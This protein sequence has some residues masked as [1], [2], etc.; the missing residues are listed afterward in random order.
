MTAT[1]EEVQKDRY[2]VRTISRI[3]G[4]P[5]TTLKDR[6]IGKVQHGINPG[7]HPREEAIRSL[8]HS[9]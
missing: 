5:K 4:V 3:Y 9:W 8:G 1:L 2:S 6:V 7:L